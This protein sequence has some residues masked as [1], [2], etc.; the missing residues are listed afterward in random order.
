MGHTDT[1]TDRQ[2][3]RVT[4]LVL[5]MLAQRQD[6]KTYRHIDRTAVRPRLKDRE[7]KVR[8]F[9]VSK[10]TYFFLFCFI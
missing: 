2:T 1:Q 10:L 6:V 8:D 5:E 3:Q 9:S 7:K 4:W